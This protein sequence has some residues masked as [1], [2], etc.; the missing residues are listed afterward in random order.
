VDWHLIIIILI[1]ILE[2][3]KKKVSEWEE[4]YQQEA[5]GKETKICPYCGRPS[6]K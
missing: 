1:V 4:I 6:L 5:F 3:K 2:I